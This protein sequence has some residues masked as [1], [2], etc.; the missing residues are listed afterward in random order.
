MKSGGK[1]KELADSCKS[2]WQHTQKWEAM[3]IEDTKRR[4]QDVCTTQKA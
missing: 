2:E 4:V 3:K 1:E